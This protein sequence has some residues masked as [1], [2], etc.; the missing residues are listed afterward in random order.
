MKEFDNLPTAYAHKVLVCLL[1]EGNR[2]FGKAL[3]IIS[4]PKSVR[5]FS[6]MDVEAVLE[7]AQVICLITLIAFLDA[8]KGRAEIILI[9]L[10]NC[11]TSKFHVA[12]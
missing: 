6:L 9:L 2:W 7:A 1:V 4:C 10:Q 5:R 12:L 3:R 8:Y 11:R